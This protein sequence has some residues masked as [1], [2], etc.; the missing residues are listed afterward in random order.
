MSGAFFIMGSL[1]PLVVCLKRSNKRN[2]RDS[3]VDESEAGKILEEPGTLTE[4]AHERKNSDIIVHDCV[5]SV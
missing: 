3:L 2:M 4:S 5:S 1:I